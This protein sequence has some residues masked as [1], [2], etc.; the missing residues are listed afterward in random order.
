[1]KIAAVVFNSVL[2]D[3]RV[4]KEA[5]S[6]AH[7]GHE[8]VLF[9]IRDN[10]VSEETYSTAGGVS[11]RLADWQKHFGYRL[12]LFLILSLFVFPLLLLPLAWLAHRLLSKL[13]VLLDIF[14]VW[15]AEILTGIVMVAVSVAYFSFWWKCWKKNRRQPPSAQLT[16]FPDLSRFRVS[17]RALIDAVRESGIALAK[18]YRLSI[19]RSALLTEICEF[20]PDVVHCHDVPTL[21]IGLAIKK[22]L[23]SK[24]VF[25][26]HEIYE[27]M[28]NIA[29]P[30]RW[31]A[32]YYQKKAASKLDGMITVNPCIAD[33]LHRKYS[34]PQPVVICNACPRPEPFPS[35]DGRLRKAANLGPSTN[36]LLFQGGLA[37]HRGLIPLIHSAPLLPANW[38]IVFMGRGYFEEDLKELAA[39]VDPS[40]DKIRFI[41]QVPQNELL[42]WTAGASLGIIPYENVCLNH[43]YC[44]PNKIWEYSAAG[45]PMLVSPFPF[46]QETV[47]RNGIGW[48]LPEPITPQGIARKVAE[49]SE[50]DLARAR[51]ACRTFALRDNWT[52]YEQRLITLYDGFGA[53]RDRTR[54]AEESLVPAVGEQDRVLGRGSNLMDMK[55]MIFITGF[56]RGGTSWLRDCVAFHPQVEKIPHEMLLFRDYNKRDQIEAEIEKA[57]ADCGLTAPRLVNKAPANAPYIGKACALFP[58]SKFLFIIR[59]PRDVFVSHKRGT[60]AW[61]GGKNSTVKGCMEKI[62]KYWAGYEAAKQYPNIMLV[63]YEDLHQAFERTLQTVYDF[64][65]LPYDGDLISRAFETLN[66]QA[67]TG[68]RQEDRDSAKRKGVVGDWANFLSREEMRFYQCDTF[69]KNFLIQQQYRS[70]PITYDRI[71]RAMR[72]G[73]VQCLGLEDVLNFRLAKDRP[74]V[75]ILHDIDLLSTEQS[76]GSVIRCAETEAQYGFSGIYNFLPLDDPRYNPCSR[77]AILAVIQTLRR[78]N[79]KTSIGLHLNAAEKF[80]PKDLP[81]LGEQPPGMD[82]AVRY[83]H[84]QIDDYEKEG[85]RF[86]IATAHGYGRKKKRPNN[87]DSEIFSAEL[88]KRGILLFDRDINLQLRESASCFMRIHDVGGALTIKRIPHAGEIDATDTYRRLPPGSLILMLFHPGNYDIERS[89]TLGFRTYSEAS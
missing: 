79:P 15:Y 57:V 36:I 71:L 75:F 9:G 40:S 77:N 13:D 65:E 14:S 19:F 33:F 89:L 48:T 46:L 87:L 88:H 28:A 76:R 80:F 26:S 72:E 3:A 29:P 52:K 17:G 8:V 25:D 5:D 64:L 47:E 27:D 16:V 55:Q 60:K 54:P 20:A 30:F 59:D 49:L 39:R 7:A 35:D 50:A 58:E 11:I 78:V 4:K 67:Q 66:F 62:R 6:L 12:R 61:M 37:K 63:R 51:A 86:Q 69:W 45:L 22:K 73:G 24:I 83:L 53:S 85:I 32:V 41:P 82:E 74:N 43:W 81:D 31:M 18:L 44:S 42:H 70:E 1:M 56:A 23:G 34:F 2:H 21:P 10:R 38:C 68:R 84:Q